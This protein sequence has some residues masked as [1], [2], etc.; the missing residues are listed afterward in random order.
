MNE[1]DIT[2]N[3]I[4]TIGFYI[5]LRNTIYDETSILFEMNFAFKQIESNDC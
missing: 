5:E 4:N 3:H 1:I 2:E